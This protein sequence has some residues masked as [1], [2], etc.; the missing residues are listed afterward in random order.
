MATILN[1]RD[2][3][4]QAADPRI[5]QTTSITNA[6]V[7]T[8]TKPKNVVA[9]TPASTNLIVTYTGFG[10]SSPT[11]TITWAYASSMYATSWNSLSGATNDFVNRTSTYSLSSATFDAHRSTNS[12]VTYR[13]TIS[14][15]GW[16]TTQSYITITYL[17]QSDDAPVITI[18]RPAIVVPFDT[19]GT[20][21]YTG[22]E[23]SISVSI[24]SSVLTYGTSGANTFSVT[25]GTTSGTVAPGT[26]TN[27]S[28]GTISGFTT[29]TAATIRYT[30]NVR[31]SAAVS[32][33]YTIDQSVTKAA[34]GT[35]GTNGNN[36]VSASIT[37]GA[38]AITYD[39]NSVN[40]SPSTTGT[41]SASLSGGTAASYSW[42]SY[43]SGTSGSGSS[44]TFTPGV[45]TSYNVGTAS[46]VTCT[47]TSTLGYTVSQTVPV[48]ITK[49]GATGTSI[50]GPSGATAIYAYYVKS[51]TA[52]PTAPSVPTG[53]V[54]NGTA[55]TDSG[56]YN[57]PKATLASNDWQFMASGTYNA[58]TTT[59]SWTSP[60]Y[61][62]TFKV[63]KLDALS[64]DIGTITAGN[65]NT[66]GSANIKGTGAGV[67]YP[68]TYGI[69]LNRTCAVQGNSSGAQAIGV[70]GVSSVSE[71]IGVVGIGAYS[72]GRSYGILGASSYGS[73]ATAGVGV[74]AYSGGLGDNAIIV[75]GGMRIH[76][77]SLHTNDL[78]LSGIDA[79]YGGGYGTTYSTASYTTILRS[80]AANFYIL[81][82]AASDAQGN[83]DSSRP[84]YIDFTTNVTHIGK[85]DLLNGTN[86]TGRTFSNT[87]VEINVGGISKYLPLYT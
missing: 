56:W 10:T 15:T 77:G 13:V 51:G 60:S 19:T 59:Y 27:S 52:L 11:P 58:S 6:T 8:F 63:G 20:A 25:A 83:Y 79:G 29:G 36:G 39:V 82:T 24:G 17:Q 46:Y 33:T 42:S 47:I 7:S 9:V 22:T 66:S 54:T 55:V 37:G 43:I 75:D 41:Y 53:S 18:S 72:S 28:F 71:G 84:F 67:L 32:R 34:S 62:A 61:L 38:R 26:Q 69:N 2:I 40:P 35:N 57:S 73:G 23:T 4:L 70:G 68:A 50:T 76:R 64:A 14:Q 16:T 65:L 5:L 74:Y 81:H 78:R 21:S 3:I 49:T 44:S 86:G 30:V 85:L 45:G 12:S 48:A 1:E 87:Y 31:D 80:D